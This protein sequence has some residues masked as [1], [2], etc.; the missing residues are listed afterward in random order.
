[1]TIFSEQALLRRQQR[2]S[3]AFTELERPALILVAAGE[4]ISKPGG[5]DQCFPYWPHPE[6]YWLTGSRRPGGVMAYDTHSET[7][8]HFVVPVSDAERL[9]EGSPEEPQGR[10]LHELQAWLDTHSNKDIIRLGAHGHQATQALTAEAQ[11]RLDHARR[12]KDDEELALMRR[13]ANATAAGHAY[14]AGILEP[15][16]TERQLQIELEAEMFRHGADD[17]GYGTII[18]AGSR[19]AILHGHPTDRVIAPNEYLLVDAGGSILGYTADVTRTLATSQRFDERHRAIY[20]IVHQALNV[21]IKTAKNGTEWHDVHRASAQ[22]IA[23]GLVELGL[24]LGE[25]AALCESGAVALFFPHGVGHMVGLGVRDVGGQ[26]PSRAQGRACCGVRVRVD[27]PLEPGFVM[28][29]EPGLYFVDALLDDPQKRAAYKDVVAWD[30]LDAWRGIGGVRLEDNIL[31]TPHG[32]PENL[33]A[34]IP[35]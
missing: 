9:W 10:P 13:A 31:I 3:A 21:G 11:Q 14:L 18:N 22:V 24:L 1:M 28:T 6:Y 20:D 19:A 4:P 25:P 2:A 5:H 23:Q 7:W 26:H 12:P 35:R 30:K 15:G 32:E 33:T 27:L 29:V 16:L 8:T 17:M 34:M